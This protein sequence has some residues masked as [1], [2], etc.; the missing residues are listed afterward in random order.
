MET[1]WC[2]GVSV[3]VYRTYSRDRG[4]SRDDWKIAHRRYAA[5]SARQRVDEVA[6]EWC[7]ANALARAVIIACAIII[8]SRVKAVARVTADYLA[9]D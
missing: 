7:G 6:V 9:R 1:I 8:E 2:T 3:R 4:N 5:S